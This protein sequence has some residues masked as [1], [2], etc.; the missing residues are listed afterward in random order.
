MPV[1]LG[2]AA[3]LRYL[4]G[5]IPLALSYIAL[6]LTKLITRTGLIV[7]ALVSLIMTTMITAYG[8]FIEIAVTYL[9]PDFSH[10]MTSILPDNFHAYIIAIMSTRIVVFLFDLKERLLNYAHRIL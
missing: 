1:L 2:L 10:L 7:T 5:F 6:L 3:V 4:T 8:Y 9:P